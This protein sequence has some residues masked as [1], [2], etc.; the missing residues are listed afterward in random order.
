MQFFTVIIAST[1][2]H[3]MYD[4]CDVTKL[5]EVERKYMI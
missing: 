3:N 4:N 5:F 2:I 1:A